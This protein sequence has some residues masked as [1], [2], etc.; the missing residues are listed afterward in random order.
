MEEKK[1]NYNKIPDVFGKREDDARDYLAKRKV[2]VKKK[3]IKKFNLAYKSGTVIK[4]EPPIGTKIKETE[5]IKL[6]VAENR[7][8]T[9]FLVVVVILLSI[10][11][12][13]GYKLSYVMINTHGPMIKADYNG[14]VKTNIVRVVTLSEMENFTNY[15]YCLT[16]S[17]TY[18]SCVWNN[19]ETDFMTVSDSGKWYVYFRAYNRDNKK[20]SLPSN[21]LQVLIDR[22]GPDIKTSFV[23]NKDKITFEV[24]A[25]D[26]LSGVKTISYSLDGNTYKETYSTFDITTTNITK[27]YIK[28][29][30]QLDNETIKEVTI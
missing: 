8:F 16:T 28:V 19:L 23:K 7:I 2:K 26:D 10:I 12:T 4:T 17:S 29:V 20:Y 14:Y 27:I 6:Y 9:M 13:Y 24:D 11:A 25:K 22:V 21:R 18:D 15:Q 3:A 5:T 30:D 1:V